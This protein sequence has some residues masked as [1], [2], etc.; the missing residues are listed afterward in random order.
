MLALTEEQQAVQTSI[1]RFARREL[2]WKARQLDNAPAGTVD[3]ELL[4]K[5]SDVGLISCQ[6]PQDYGGTMGRLSAVVALEELAH[7]EAGIAT[8]L[9][10]N[11]QAQ[12]AVTL[13]SNKP[14]MERLC[15]DILASEVQRKPLF[16]ALALTERHAGSDLLQA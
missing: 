14:L 5:S 4:R 13:S 15:A 2:R 1:R 8:L 9:A 7:W 11:S 16:G 3:W 12:L 10:Y 6:L